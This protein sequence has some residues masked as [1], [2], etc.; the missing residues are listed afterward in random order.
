MKKAQTSVEAIL[1]VSIVLASVVF[2][3]TTYSK[4]SWSTIAETV[5]KNQV[6]LELN[7]HKTK[8]P[9]C[10]GTYL[11]GLNKTGNWTLYFSDNEC[12][13]NIF[14]EEKLLSIQRKVSA[15]LGCSKETEGACK[16]LVVDLEIAS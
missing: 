15:A 10:T 13:S 11:T 4:E 16:G 6:E 1:I 2:F 14:D 3:Y 7:K 12:A 5:V 8:L 9:N